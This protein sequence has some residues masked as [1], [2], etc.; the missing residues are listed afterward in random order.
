MKPNFQTLTDK[1]G[2]EYP[3]ACIPIEKINEVK[4]NKAQLDYTYALVTIKNN[5][6][7]DR[8]LIGKVDL[9]EQLPERLGDQIKE[10][11]PTH[12]LLYHA[13]ADFYIIHKDK[14]WDFGFKSVL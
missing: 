9:L 14:L 6:I 3:F 12:L 5:E 13:Y 1:N 8:Q 2:Y 4:Y 10:L 7:T 11:Q